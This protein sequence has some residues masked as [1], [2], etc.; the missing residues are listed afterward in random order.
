M[1]SV[2]IQIQLI[3]N[4]HVPTHTPNTSYDASRRN[5]IFPIQTFACQLRK[6]Q[7]GRAG[8]ATLAVKSQGSTTNNTSPWIK[9]LS[10]PISRKKLATLQVP[11][12]RLFTTTFVRC[13]WSD[14]NDTE[15]PYQA[16]QCQFPLVIPQRCSS[17]VLGCASS[18]NIKTIKWDTWAV[19]QICRTYMKSIILI[20]S[21]IQHIVQIFS[22]FSQRIHKP[23]SFYGQC[24]IGHA[25]SRNSTISTCIDHQPG[26]QT[27]TGRCSANTAYCSREHGDTKAWLPTTR[28]KASHGVLLSI[29]LSYILVCVVTCLQPICG[30]PPSTSDRL[31]DWHKLKTGT[32]HQFSVLWCAVCQS[33]RIERLTDRQTEMDTS[34]IGRSAI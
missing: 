10:N 29:R 25:F 12:A 33:V 14:R 16:P 19:S 8:R 1:P 21:S 23:L 34:E 24:G 20:N 7:K 30:R 17:Y 11:F 4:D 2:T 32:R 27:P 9:Q 13:H 15:I 3:L 31:T 5:V 22:S 6:L 26:A 28:R 18:N